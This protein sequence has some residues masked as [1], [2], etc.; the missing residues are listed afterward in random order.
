MI[1]IRGALVRD[2]EARRDLEG[3]AVVIVVV[4]PGRGLPVEFR[5]HYGPQARD[6][7]LAQQVARCLPQ[8]TTLEVRADGCLGV[9]TDHDLARLLMMQGTMQTTSGVTL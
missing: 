7:L 8:G 9:V 4:N 2:A 3:R 5:R 1:K 6:M